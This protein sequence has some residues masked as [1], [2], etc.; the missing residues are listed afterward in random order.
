VAYD[1]TTPRSWLRDRLQGLMLA[2]TSGGLLTVSLLALLAGPDFGH[3]LG[4]VIRSRRR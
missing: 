4:T 2:C 1:V 3:F